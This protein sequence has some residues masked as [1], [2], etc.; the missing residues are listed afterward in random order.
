MA[1]KPA[2]PKEELVS[3]AAAAKPAVDDGSIAQRVDEILQKALAG[4]ATEIHFEPFTDRTRLRLRLHGRLIEQEGFEARLHGKLINRLKVMSGVDISKR[5]VAQRGYS[6][7]EL[8]QRTFDLTTTIVPTP[9]GEKALIRINYLT[10]LGVSL[11]QLGM[12]PQTLAS[13][14]RLLDRP[15]GL[16]LIAGPPGSGRTTT[17]YTCLQYLNRPEK[18]VSTFE[19]DHR[20][21]IPGV[22]Q[23]KPDARFEYGWLDGLRATIDLDPDVLFVGQISDEETARMTLATAFGKRMVLG[24]INSKNG[25]TAMMQLLDMGLPGF[26]VA[27]GVIGVLTQRLVRRLCEACRTPYQPQDS[28]LAEL[29][30]KQ[31]PEITFYASKG[32]DKCHGTGFRGMLGLFELFVPTEK[33]QEKVIARASAQDISA[34][35]LETGYLPLR[36][37]GVIKVSRGLT[38]LEEVLA[39][40]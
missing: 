39:R 25:P 4:G 2:Q 28:M 40:L 6:K 34:S 29:G 17:C 20:Y 24:R 21:L 33:V 31:G 12:F 9:F 1:F 8:E 14:K 10:A 32:C 23:G 19:P 26:L 35:A 37:D 38:T 11:D 13:L 18:N 27:S 30:V 5:G 36:T 16:I 7:F 15:N 22:I 3:S